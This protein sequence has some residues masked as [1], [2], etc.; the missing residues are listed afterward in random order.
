MTESNYKRDII[1]EF[2]DPLKGYQKSP[3]RSYFIK[4]EIEDY[5]ISNLRYYESLIKAKDALDIFQ[6]SL[7]SQLVPADL[8]AIDLKDAY[9]A[10]AAITGDDFTEDLLDNIFSKFCIGK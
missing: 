6:E 4:D 7:S 2:F 3:G 10:L 5:C 9:I 1:Q 8:L